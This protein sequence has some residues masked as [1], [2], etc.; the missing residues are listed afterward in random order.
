MSNFCQANVLITG[1]HS[2][3]CSRFRTKFCLV[4]SSVAIKSSYNYPVNSTQHYLSTI[5]YLLIKN[6]N[7]H[8]NNN[9]LRHNSQYIFQSF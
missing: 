3:K 9:R 2:A 8:R 1:T 7:N 6:D 4:V 5:I